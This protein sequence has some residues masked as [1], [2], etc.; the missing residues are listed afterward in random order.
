MLVGDSTQSGLKDIQFFTDYN[1]SSKTSL[2]EQSVI[3][4][5]SQ[6][7]V[8][9]SLRYVLPLIMSPFNIETCARPN[10]LALQP[11]RCARE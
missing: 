7:W 2:L 6:S 9:S 1:P 5:E 3:L 10:I 4:K 11:Y 8:W